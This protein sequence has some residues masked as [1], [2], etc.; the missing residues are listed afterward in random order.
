ME[1]NLNKHY[2][3][4]LD[5]S[6]IYC[7]IKFKVQNIFALTYFDSGFLEISKPAYIN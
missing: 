1:I 4:I 5:L 3:N 7:Q 2:R 6:N